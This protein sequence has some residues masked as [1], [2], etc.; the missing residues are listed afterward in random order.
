MKHGVAARRD[1]RG[2][3]PDAPRLRLVRDAGR[4]SAGDPAGMVDARWDRMADRVIGASSLVSTAALL[5]VREFAW[6]QELREQW[7]AIRVEATAVTG[8]GEVTD[9]YFPVTAALLSQVPGLYAARF[10]RVVPGVQANLRGFADR[11]L[12]TCHL[13]LVVPRNGDLRMR[14]GGRTVRWAEG[15][16]LLF[17]ATQAQGRWNDGGEAGML[18]SL[19]LRRPLRQPAR[20]L[21]ERLLR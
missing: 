11:A 15:E 7:R 16:T 3:A 20:W 8:D 17:D 10:E 14:L 21:A 19:Q 9:R 13:G 18:L 2:N 1:D 6:T 12:L 4:S 5:D